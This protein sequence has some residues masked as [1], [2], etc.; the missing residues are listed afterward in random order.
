M[1]WGVSPGRTPGHAGGRE[2]KHADDKDDSDYSGRLYDLADGVVVA[3]HHVSGKVNGRRA[4]NLTEVRR[5]LL[6]TGRALG[7]FRGGLGGV[8]LWF[9]GGVFWVG[10]WHLC[11]DLCP[12]GVEL[13]AE[14]V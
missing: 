11:A 4:E 1:N 10:R 8:M 5:N 3:S 13:G 9:G 7:F 2:L 6:R 14:F 12:P